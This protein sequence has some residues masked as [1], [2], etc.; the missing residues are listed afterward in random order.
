[1]KNNP[2]RIGFDFDKV[3]VDYPPLIPDFV[4][5][6]LYK[7]KDKKLSYRFPGK[8][9]QQI[10]IA[11]HHPLLRPPIKNNIKSLENIIKDKKYEI[12]LISSRFSFLK[13]RTQQWFEENKINSL[14][15][16]IY[17]N[18]DN[19][20][21]HEF[22]NKMIQSLHINRYVDD[23][24]DTL[25]YLALKNKDIVFFWIIKK[26]FFINSKLPNNVIPVTDIEEIRNKYL[27]K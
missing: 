17:F 18:F 4:I 25:N 16:H 27:Q 2:Q 6:R 8:I 24:L 15:K 10:R 22:K 9:E 5:D 21:P 11:S 7:N 13:K 12:Y 20:Q 1:M 14:F 3:F 19:E 23:D 26:S